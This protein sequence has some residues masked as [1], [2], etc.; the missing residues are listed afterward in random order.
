MDQLFDS[1]NVMCS[2]DPQQGK[3]ITA[4]AMFRGNMPTSE[5]EESMA[6][7]SQKNSSNFI[8]WI[9]YNIQVSI[10]DIPPKGLRMSATLIANSTSV[11]TVYR[12]IGEQFTN[13]FRR[14]AFLHWYTGQGMDEMEFSEA[15]SNLNDLVSEF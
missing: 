10:C 15:E 5:V 14:K 12:R 9:P 1:E 2:C 11:S 8:E 7:K 6:S 4:S 13:L 3:Y